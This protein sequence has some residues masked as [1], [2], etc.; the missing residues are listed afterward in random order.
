MSAAD[1]EKSL[2]ATG[3]VSSD[4]SNSG[5]PD[6]RKVEIHESSQDEALDQ[7]PEERAKSVRPPYR[8]L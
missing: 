6:G 2:P 4:D 5:S 3:A 7:S 8:K 1:P